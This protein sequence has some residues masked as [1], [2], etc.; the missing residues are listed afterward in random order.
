[1]LNGKFHVVG[2]HLPISPSNY[3]IDLK[4]TESRVDMTSHFD[5]SPKDGCCIPFCCLFRGCRRRKEVH[6]IFDLDNDA[7]TLTLTLSTAFGGLITCLEKGKV[8]HFIGV[9]SLVILAN[10]KEIF[11]LSPTEDHVDEAT[12]AQIKVALATIDLKLIELPIVYL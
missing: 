5:V 2:Y 6:D 3:Q 12:Q 7:S 11:I 4:T 10:L 8:F 1:M 9:E